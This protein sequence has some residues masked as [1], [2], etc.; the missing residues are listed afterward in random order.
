MYILE[1]FNWEIQTSARIHYRSV[2]WSDFKRKKWDTSQVVPDC[3][4]KPTT[5][6]HFEML[7]FILVQGLMEPQK[8]IRLLLPSNQLKN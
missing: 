7:L 6:F 8:K 1:W 2:G 5:K 4:W 3:Y